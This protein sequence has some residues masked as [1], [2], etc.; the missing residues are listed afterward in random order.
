MLSMK[1]KTYGALATIVKMK[2]GAIL[3]GFA[4][5]LVQNSIATEGP[6]KRRPPMENIAMK[7]RRRRPD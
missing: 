4:R 1:G 3:S 6:E 2:A 5:S 7:I